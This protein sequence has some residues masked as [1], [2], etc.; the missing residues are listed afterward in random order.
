MTLPQD[1]DQML[2][3]NVGISLCSGDRCVAEKL[4]NNSYVNTIPQ[5]QSRY[6]VS[7]HMWSD[8]AF[9]SSVLSKLSDD[10]CDALSR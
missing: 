8:I 9:D 4:L 7:Q 3:G 6:G 5:Q 1:A 2:F 10:I